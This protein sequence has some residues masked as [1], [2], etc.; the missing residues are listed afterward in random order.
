MKNEI[1]KQDS[2]DVARAHV[3]NLLHLGGCGY[4]ISTQLRLC[5]MSTINRDSSSMDDAAERYVLEALGCIRFSTLTLS[6][7][8][9]CP[10]KLAKDVP[11]SSFV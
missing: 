10:F 9:V 4:S 6:V 2:V 8:D 11:F 5:C 3:D 1:D 7:A